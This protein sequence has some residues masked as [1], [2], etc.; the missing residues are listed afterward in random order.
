LSPGIHFFPPEADNRA[1][2]PLSLEGIRELAT[3]LRVEANADGRPPLAE[4]VNRQ[5]VMRHD[6]E[7][8][9]N[10]QLRH[11]RFQTE[12]DQ[13]EQAFDRTGKPQK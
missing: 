3:Y 2:R 7:Y 4:Q 13:G 11:W 12:S 5:R 10:G 8:W 6:Y 9:D 1:I